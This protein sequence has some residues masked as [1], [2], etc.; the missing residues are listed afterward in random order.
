M[1]VLTIACFVLL[2]AGVLTSC[3]KNYVL[4]SETPLDSL[5]IGLIAYYQFKNS[6]AD[7]SGK[8]NNVTYYKN[9]TSVANRL[10]FSNSAFSFDGQNSY[11]TVND[12]NDLRLSNTDFTLNAWVKLNSFSPNTGTYIL[13]K[14]TS[15]L[16]S[17]WGFSV[18]GQQT[19]VGVVGGV[20]FGPG[21]L[22]ASAVST[23]SISLNKWSMVTVIYNSTKQQISIYI[24]GVLDNVTNNIPA[25]NALITANMFIGADNPANGTF[26]YTYGALDDIRIYNRALS[27]SSVQKLYVSLN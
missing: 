3:K 15:G 8:A 16:N 19:N 9:I 2:T 7:S 27:A 18:N 4:Q 21:G 17:G 1:K 13:S 14:R 25:P 26:Y 20:Y 6:G 10:N 22:N 11:L 5:R 12:N 24:D 23:K